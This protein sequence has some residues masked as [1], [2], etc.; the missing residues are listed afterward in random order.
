MNMD[1]E[2]CCMVICPIVAGKVLSVYKEPERCKIWP[3]LLYGFIV[4]TFSLKITI[5]CNDLPF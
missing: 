2:L 3:T 5:S 4:I 1:D